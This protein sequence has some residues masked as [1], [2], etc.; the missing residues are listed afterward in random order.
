M[1]LLGYVGDEVGSSLSKVDQSDRKEI[2]LFPS[3]WGNFQNI[4]MIPI[5]RIFKSN[6]RR[7]RSPETG[8][9]SVLDILI[10]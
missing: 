1:I 5:N 7:I 3:M 6:D 8:D 2:I 10:E 4:V 9:I